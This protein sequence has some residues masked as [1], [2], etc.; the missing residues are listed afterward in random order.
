[1]SLWV[2]VRGAKRKVFVFLR[3]ARKKLSYCVGCAVQLTVEIGVGSWFRGF[4]A[5]ISRF[6][7]ATSTREH[8]TCMSISRAAVH[9]PKCGCKDES[10]QH[11][12]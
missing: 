4:Q 9:E 3:G 6:D 2:A 8:K 12:V 10:N 5:R 1:M 7:S 11:Q